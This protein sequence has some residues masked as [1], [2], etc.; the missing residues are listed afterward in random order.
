MKIATWSIVVGTRACNAHCDFCISQSSQAVD[1]KTLVTDYIDIN[2]INFDSAHKL[3]V[4]ANAT[5]VLLTGRGEPTLYPSLISQYLLWLKDSPIPFKELQTNGILLMK[6]RDDL[7]YWRSL[8]LNTICLSCVSYCTRVNQETYSKEYPPLV[9]T[10]QF[11]KGMG[12]T[13]RLSCMLLKGHIDNRD[14]LRML[15]G[16]CKANGVQQ[17]TV[18]PITAPDDATDSVSNWIKEHTVRNSLLIDMEMML[19]NEGKVLMRLPHGGIVYDFDG[20]NVCFT[21]CLTESKDQE[22]MRQIIFFP[23][24]TLSYSWQNAGAVLL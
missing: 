21:N 2:K 22:D 14:D 6:M 12:F 10:I 7:A 8:G 16:F 3:A 4:M 1:D 24:G 23:C 18:R 11:L 17:L 15:I 5:T 19:K 20:Q 9:D 13:I